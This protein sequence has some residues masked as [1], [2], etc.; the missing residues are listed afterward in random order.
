M[1]VLVAFASANGSTESIARA[2]GD[3]LTARGCNVVL[4]PVG[5][6]RSVIAATTSA[7]SNEGESVAFDAA[8]VGSAV[9]SGRWLPE[10]TAFVREAAPSLENHPV[11][12]FSVCSIGETTSFLG[13]RISRFTRARR[14]DSKEL[15]D[16]RRVTSCRDHR[17]FAGVVKKGQWNRF[18]DLFLLLT[19]GRHGDQRDW[20]DIEQWANHIADQLTSEQLA[21]NE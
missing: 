14:R 13:E 1:K 18:G 20:T 19:G 10:A 21:R 16:L 8:V 9:H 3:R 12:L 4:G 5:D 7:G 2:I 11:W 15:A 17:Y 6:M